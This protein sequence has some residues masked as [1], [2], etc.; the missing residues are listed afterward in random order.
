MFNHILVYSRETCYFH[1]F[2]MRTS[3]IIET[4]GRTSI[5][6]MCAILFLIMIVG[7][8]VTEARRSEERPPVAVSEEQIPALLRAIPDWKEAIRRAKWVDS[9]EEVEAV[10]GN[11]AIVEIIDFSKAVEAVAVRYPEGILLLLEYGTPQLSAD[12]DKRFNSFLAES[13]K[14]PKPL[15]KRIGNYNAFVFNPSGD[16]GGRKLLDRV[17]YEK[18]VQWLGEDP[19]MSERLDRYVAATTAQ[20]LFSTILTIAIGLGTTLTFGITLGFLFFR[21]RQKQ[22]KKLKTFSDAGGMIRINL[23]GFSDQAGDDDQD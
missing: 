3:T 19:N 18:V 10:V 5:G 22:R 14:V 15:Y 1:N 2:E 11:Q 23:D 12:A 21:Y 6:V 20:L 16:D 7:V 8:G 9:Q 4:V 17:R 13:Q